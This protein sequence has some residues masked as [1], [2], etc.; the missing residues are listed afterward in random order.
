MS[1]RVASVSRLLFRKVGHTHK[2]HTHEM[3]KRQPSKLTR[4]VVTTESIDF[5][6]P[7]SAK[8]K[9]A[10]KYKN[11][12]IVRATST[13]INGT[14]YTDHK[15]VGEARRKQESNFFYHNQQ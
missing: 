8:T 5:K 15:D 2:T 1:E 13:T 10:W 3:V 11:N 9:Q 14:K 12:N 4:K 7:H 6:T